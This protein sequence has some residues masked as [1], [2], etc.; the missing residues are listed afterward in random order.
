[1][2]CIR[3]IFPMSAN[4]EK[5]IQESGMNEEARKEAE[6][7]AEPYETGGAKTATNTVCS[8]DYTGFY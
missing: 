2:R 1:M 5:K 4:F 3:K 7:V 8:Y 6:K